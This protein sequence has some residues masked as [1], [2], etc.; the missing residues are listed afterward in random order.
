[1]GLRREGVAFRWAAAAAVVAAATTRGGAGGC[2]SPPY[3]SGWVWEATFL[4][5]AGKRPGGGGD[6]GGQAGEG[7]GRVGRD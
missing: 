1:M 3:V 4:E 2:E 7:G 6:A 5:A